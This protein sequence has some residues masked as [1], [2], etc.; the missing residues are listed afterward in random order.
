VAEFWTLGIIMRHL[1]TITAVAVAVACLIVFGGCM[2]EHSSEQIKAMS[3]A[4]AFTLTNQVAPILIKAQDLNHATTA[5]RRKTNRWPVDSAELRHFVE[6]SDG[7]LSLEKYSSVDLT[8]L[9]AGCLLIRFVPQGETNQY[10]LIRMPDKQ[11]H[12]KW[13]ARDDWPALI[14]PV[15]GGLKGL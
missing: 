9:S 1:V 7:T 11:P 5:F 12:S 15:L 8:N 3:E 2:S 10:V 14:F 4:L 13:D 6:Q